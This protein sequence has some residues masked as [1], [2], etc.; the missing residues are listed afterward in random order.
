[1]WGSGSRYLF[2]CCCCLPHPTTPHMKSTAEN[3]GANVQLLIYNLEIHSA[4]FHF[5]S[6]N[7]DIDFSTRSPRHVDFKKQVAR[8]IP[9]SIGVGKTRK[10]KMMS[11]MC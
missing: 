2:C 8:D 3:V 10:R 4:C 1:M 6:T 9:N 11:M 5:R 7:N